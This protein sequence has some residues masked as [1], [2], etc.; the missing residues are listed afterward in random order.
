MQETITETETETET[1][2]A[3]RSGSERYRSYHGRLVIVIVIVSLK[4]IGEI[5]SPLLWEINDSIDRKRN[6]DI[7]PQLS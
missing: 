2:V 7:T 4:R 5:T 1:E 3:R 6:G